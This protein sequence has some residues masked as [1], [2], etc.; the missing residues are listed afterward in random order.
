VWFYTQSVVFTH[1]RV[2]LTRIRVNLILTSVI[3]TRTSVISTRRVYIPH[4]VCDLNNRGICILMRVIW[5]LLHVILARY[6]SNQHTA[7]LKPYHTA[8]QFNTHT[9]RFNMH[10]CRFNTYS[11]LAFCYLLFLFLFSIKHR[12]VDLTRMRVFKNKLCALNQHAAWLIVPYCV[13]I[14]Q[15]C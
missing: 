9:W 5:I 11:C 8:C 6:V 2:R 14:Q 13:V 7:A 10:A 3:M 12:L 15:Y 1:T 4:F